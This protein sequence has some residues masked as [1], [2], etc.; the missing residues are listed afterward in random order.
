MEGKKFKSI[1]HIKNI[2]ATPDR[3]FHSIYIFFIFFQLYPT[4]FDIINKIEKK[5]CFS[6]NY[7]A[8]LY[9]QG[10]VRFFNA[11]SQVIIQFPYFIPFYY[12]FLHFNFFFTFH[13]FPYFSII[14]TPIYVIPKR[15]KMK[16]MFGC[17]QGYHHHK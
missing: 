2:S 8:S 14:F 9:L 12:P 10:E 13:P 3:Y 11:N 17:C 5:W 4:I 15:V 7:P 16:W 1:N 6:L